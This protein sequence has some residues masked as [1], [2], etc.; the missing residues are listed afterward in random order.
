ML[1]NR[2]PRSFLSAIIVIIAAFAAVFCQSA[3]ADSLIVVD[4]HTTDVSP[5]VL[6]GTGSHLVD[7]SRDVA[8]NNGPFAALA[9]R[10][11]TAVFKV[12]TVNNLLK[13]SSNSTGTSLTLSDPHSGEVKTFIGATKEEAQANMQSFLQKNLNRAFVGYQTTLNGASSLGVTDGNPLAATA[14]LATDAFNR[15]GIDPAVPA[16]PIGQVG[17]FAVGFDVGGG[18]FNGSG[19]DGDFAQFD[20]NFSG[21]FNQ[22]IG[23]VL[24]V[25]VEYREIRGTNS[26]VGGANLG[27]PFTIIAHSPGQNG[28]AWQAT[29]WGVVGG[30]IN[31]SLASGGGIAGGGATSS[32]AYHLQK[33]TFTM[34]NQAGYD[35]GFDFPYGDFKFNTPVDQWIIKNGIYADYTT[36]HGLFVDGGIAYTNFTHDAGVSSYWTPKLGGG[37]RWGQD[38]AYQIRITYVGDFGNG[39]NANAIQ[40][41]FH[42]SF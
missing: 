13:L 8:N 40:G 23:I 9:G 1:R 27:L 42:F 12:G 26:Y 15:F 37:I 10:P 33:F 32:L 3:R 34:A 16:A 7:L 2:N 18:T 11:F 14:F 35:G 19:V 25:P 39:F 20:I 31:E 38:G 4:I 24:S 29:P 36:S 21:R 22:L 30:G 6:R 5:I 28:F 41:Q 17:H